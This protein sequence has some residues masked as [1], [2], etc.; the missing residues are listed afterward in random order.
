M[1]IEKL[2]EMFEKRAKFLGFSRMTKEGDGY[3]QLG[4]DA[5]WREW[6]ACFRAVDHLIRDEALNDAIEACDE[7]DVIGADDCIAKIRALKEQ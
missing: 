2:R 7:V 1:T 6:L 4:L 3:K 5:I